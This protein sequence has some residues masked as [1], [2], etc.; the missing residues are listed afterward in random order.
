MRSVIG[1]ITLDIGP[2]QNLDRGRLMPRDGRLCEGWPRGGGE[3]GSW[4]IGGRLLWREGKRESRFPNCL[5]TPPSERL[6]SAGIQADKAWGWD[7]PSMPATSSQ[8]K[9]REETASRI[10]FRFM[11]TKC[12]QSLEA[13]QS[14]S[15]S[16]GD[17]LPRGRFTVV[18]APGAIA[19]VTGIL[20]P[21]NLAIF[22][23]EI[24]DVWL[25]RN[26]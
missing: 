5:P 14:P 25:V 18:V 2:V 3:S 21:V 15:F 10:K 7:L 26:L 12:M 13:K 24:A 19:G 23:R 6:P 22:F 1:E 16:R 4:R 17:Q 20:Q 8:R 9:I 11:N